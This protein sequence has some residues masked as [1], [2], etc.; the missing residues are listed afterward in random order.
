MYKGG[1]AGNSAFY[2]SRAWKRLSRAFL[3]SRNYICERCGQPAE[4]AHH[5]TYLTAENVTDPAI[6]LNPDNLEALCQNCHNI[7]HFGQ[8]GATAAGLAFDENGDIQKAR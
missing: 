2:H 8:G 6:A 4:I 7:E 3:L 1:T 5:K